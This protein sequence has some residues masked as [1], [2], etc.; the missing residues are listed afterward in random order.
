MKEIIYQTVC[1]GCNMGCG[2]YIR[3]DDEGTVSVDF[4]KSSPANLGKLCRFG[5]QLPHHY[6]K[7]VSL[8][9]GTESSVEDAVQAASNVLKGA[10]NVAMLSVGA[11]SNEEH[12]AFI[13]IAEA[14]GTTVST[15]IAAYAELP[16]ECHPSVGMGIPLEDI[17][18]AK[19]IALFVDPYTQYPLLVRRLLA[20]K[21]NGA[22]IVSVG[23]KD[24]NLADEN[25]HISPDQYKSELGLDSESII[26]TDVHPNTDPQKVKQML[27]LAL[28]TGA[29]IMFMKPFVDSTGVH[30]LSKGTSQ[31]GLNEIMEGINEGSI[32]TLV[33]LDSDPTE[34]MPNSDE[35]AATL[36]KLDNFVVISSRD[37]PVNQ[38]A[39]VVIATEPQYAKA[40]S[41]MNVEGQLLNN[42][43]TGTAGI[44]AMSTL[45]Q[46]LGG[47]A[48]DYQTLHSQVLESIVKEYTKP[49]Y[50]EMA[51]ELM[52]AATVEEGQGNLI[53]VYNPFMWFDQPD[54]NDFVIVNMNMVKQLGLRKGGMIALTSD[55]GA[56]NMKYKIEDVPDGLILTAKKLPVA[57]G[58]TTVVTAEAV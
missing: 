49:K 8:V 1:P 6:S 28:T 40:G 16:S 12:L 31:K 54:D 56:V 52:E 22:S 36:S 35:A 33:T 14:L 13:R 24:L 25:K 5:M 51:C 17:E 27:N 50:M 57:T 3:E 10:E 11:T 18:H 42:S 20:A 48:F 38:L 7:A 19:K 34:L 32:K 39:S 47:G 53:Y 55:N 26:I 45:C 58:C 44:D 37:S 9:D 15:G 41:F 2:L 4:M 23:Q 29:R 43:G 46:N 30:L 21:K